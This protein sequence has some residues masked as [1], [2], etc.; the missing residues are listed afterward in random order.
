MNMNHRF[1]KVAVI[2][3]VITVG[4]AHRNYSLRFIHSDMNRDKVYFENQFREKVNSGVDVSG[5]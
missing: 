2:F 5:F 4:I 3:E 1:L